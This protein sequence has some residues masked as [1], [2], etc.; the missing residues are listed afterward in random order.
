MSARRGPDPSL[1]DYLETC[2]PEAREVLDRAR[3]L[4]AAT[5]GEARPGVEV[6]ER[7]SYGI[8]TFFVGGKRLLHLAGWAEHLAIYPIP[9]EPVDDR[10]LGEELTAYVKGKGTLHFPYAAGLPDEL[11]RRIARAHLARL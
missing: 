10:T 2:G 11:I 5:V 7:L 3:E 6:S 8:P 9:P 1:Q 4:V